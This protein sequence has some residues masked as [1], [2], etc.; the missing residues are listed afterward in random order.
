MN[1]DVKNYAL[2]KYNGDE[3]LATAFAASFEKAANEDKKSS[4]AAF[5]RSLPSFGE[6]ITKG[7]GEGVGKGISGIVMGLGLHGINGIVNA[8]S[9]STLHNAFLLALQKAIASNSTLREADKARVKDYA[10]TIFKFAP[11]VA[12]DANVLSQ[13]LANAVHGEGVD[14]MTI[15]TLGDL[16]SRYME[17]HSAG[18]FTP[19]TYM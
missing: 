15:K 5:G 3:E 17:N 13:V 16:E 2:A 9:S 11:H 14:S 10:E 19:K 4:P 18:G 1:T 8:A 12:T 7:L 6:S